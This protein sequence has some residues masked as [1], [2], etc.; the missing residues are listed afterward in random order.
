MRTCQHTGEKRKG[1]PGYLKA[2][3]LAPIVRKAL[4]DGYIDH[5]SHA[6]NQQLPRRLHVDLVNALT[7]AVVGRLLSECNGLTVQPDADEG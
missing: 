3:S 6:S 2:D 4:T 1:V 7:R 5:V